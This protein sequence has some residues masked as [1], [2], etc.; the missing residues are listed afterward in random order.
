[1]S[2]ETSKPAS[3]WRFAPVGFILLALGGAYALGLH[4]Y[5]SFETLRAQRETLTAFV[6]ANPLAAAAIYIAIYGAF[7]MAMIPGA[8]WITI[9]G[10]FLFGLAGGSALTVVGATLGATALFLAARTAF[11]A[12]L[13]K[14]VGPFLSKLEAG[15]A[16][17]PLSYMFTL[18]FLPV[19]PFPVAN[20]A[21][22]LLGAK[23][24]D[25]LIATVFGII[26]GV[27]AYTWIGSGLGAAF[28]A[29]NEPEIGAFAKQLLPA[30]F[31]LAAVS[32]LPIA[33]KRLGAQKKKAS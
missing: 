28:D 26:P 14:R 1:M 30:F 4:K 16:E 13:R 20:I 25:Y 9:A 3:L 19:V 5:L 22:A 23:V 10:G 11:G 31:A 12:G 6:T 32:L 17:N 29:G 33:I 7:T 18:R 21:P 15:F 27:V 24:G 2:T 8:L